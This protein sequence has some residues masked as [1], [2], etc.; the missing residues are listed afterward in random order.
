MD[1]ACCI[2]GLVLIWASVAAITAGTHLQTQSRQFEEFRLATIR[3]QAGPGPGERLNP[4]GRMALELSFT[5]QF[6]CCFSGFFALLFTAGVFGIRAVGRR[7]RELALVAAG[8]FGLGCL[9]GA[10]LGVGEALRSFGWGFV[11]LGV[12]FLLSAAGLG[13]GGL[14]VAWSLAAPNQALQQ[15]G[16]A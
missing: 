8:A 11:T 16:G 15:T 3:E 10:A 12:G 5:W 9:G 14:G 4:A 1:R 6:G 7:H 2:T 13:V